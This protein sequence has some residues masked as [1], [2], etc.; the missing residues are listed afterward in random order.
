MTADSG[1]PKVLAEGV[2]QGQFQGAAGGVALAAAL[3]AGNRRQLQALG[4]RHGLA[5]SWHGP[6]LAGQ[7]ARLQQVNG[8]VDGLAGD[9]FARHAFAE[10]LGAVVQDAAD[11]DVV[12]RVA[13]VR[14]V[15]DRLP[16]RN[17]NQEN[18]QFRYVQEWFLVVE[19]KAHEPPP[20]GLRM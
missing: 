18:R 11:D 2:E 14:G 8:E 3:V 19:A 9:V 16:Q 12:G 17:A 1:S 20:V 10:A 5:K 6:Q 13:R 7:V 15:A 4:E